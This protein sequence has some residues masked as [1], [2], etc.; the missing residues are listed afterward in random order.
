MSLCYKR[1]KTHY[2]AR[3]LV[4]Q[5]DSHLC[6]RYRQVQAEVGVWISRT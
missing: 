1:A 3:C 6:L 2:S 5:R 4:L